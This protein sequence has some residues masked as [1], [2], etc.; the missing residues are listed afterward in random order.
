V[1]DLGSGPECNARQ[2]GSDNSVQWQHTVEHHH[3]SN[4]HD[5][6][7]EFKQPEFRQLANHFESKFCKSKLG[8]VQREPQL[9]KQHERTERI[10][11]G[12]DQWANRQLRGSDRHLRLDAE[13]IHEQPDWHVEPEHSRRQS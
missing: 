4:N 5:K 10:D 13:R 2:H 9:G 7:S 8:D 11:Y 1:C 12:C 3:D 6:Q